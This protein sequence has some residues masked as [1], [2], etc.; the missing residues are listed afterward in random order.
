MP[1]DV[2]IL[3]DCNS[4]YMHL[5]YVYTLSENLAFSKSIINMTNR[6]YL[7]HN[8]NENSLEFYVFYANCYS[9]VLA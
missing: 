9:G 4:M 8:C 7:K 2:S 1:A 5:I 3:A 6:K